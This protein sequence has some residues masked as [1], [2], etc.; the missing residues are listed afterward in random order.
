M[1]FGN[2][3]PLMGNNPFWYLGPQMGGGGSILNSMIGASPSASMATPFRSPSGRRNMGIGL[4]NRLGSAFD[5]KHRVSAPRVN[6]P[7]VIDFQ[8][9]TTETDTTIQVGS[10]F[11]LHTGQ[12]NDLSKT[13]V[14]GVGCVDV[15]SGFTDMGG[16]QIDPLTGGGAYGSGGY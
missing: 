16:N 7:T 9:P 5:P 1:A 10:D 6:Q 12:C 3:K 2:R 11:N 14:P 13:F 4:R 8:M 15:A